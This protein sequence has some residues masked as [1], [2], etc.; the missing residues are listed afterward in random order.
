M[1]TEANNTN[2]DR[3]KWA[4]AFARVRQAQQNLEAY[5]EATR[6]LKELERLHVER[7]H[8]ARNIQSAVP[9][10][11]TLDIRAEI[12]N[13]N[14]LFAVPDQVYEN[15]DVF[16][17]LLSDAEEALMSTPAPDLAALRWKLNKAAS[18]CY[19]PEYLAQMHADMDRLMGPSEA[20]SELLTEAA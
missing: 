3:A 12:L 1:T 2:P 4:I 15:E 5:I 16:G 10:K 6:P 13:A 9:Q 17:E 19:S 14:P 20:E 8:N 18:S 7:E 11:L